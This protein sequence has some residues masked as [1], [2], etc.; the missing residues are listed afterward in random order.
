MTTVVVSEK[1]FWAANEHLFDLDIVFAWK[2]LFA[3]GLAEP[4]VFG[5]GEYGIQLTE[6]GKAY[7][8]KHL[9]N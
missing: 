9:A 7:Y 4:I 2:N 6:A 1:E 5:D 8:R 3:D